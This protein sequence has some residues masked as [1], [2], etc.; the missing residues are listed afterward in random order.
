[1]GSGIAQRETLGFVDAGLA[2]L[3]P[4]TA[5]LGAGLWRICGSK[6]LKIEE[7]LDSLRW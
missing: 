3:V 1:M 4:G 5:V 7:I 6:V 2:K